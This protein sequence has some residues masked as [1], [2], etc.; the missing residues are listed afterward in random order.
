MGQAKR[1]GTFEQRREEAMIKEKA[2][3]ERLQR[4]ELMKP[5]RPK[6]THISPLLP[7]ILAMDELSY[8]PSQVFKYVNGLIPVDKPKNK[9][10]G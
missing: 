2:E 1:R 3:R 7:F 10:E 4:L 5:S 8:M 9:K 6:R